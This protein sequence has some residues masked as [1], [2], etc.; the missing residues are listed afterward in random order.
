MT[1]S[2][3]LACPDC[4]HGFSHVISS[5]AFPDRV[6]RRR[7]CDGCGHRRTTNERAGRR[8]C[9]KLSVAEI[10]AAVK[11]LLEC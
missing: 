9:G 8:E 7:V 5:R 4:A 2:P 6:R 3:G 1:T 11:E 10:L